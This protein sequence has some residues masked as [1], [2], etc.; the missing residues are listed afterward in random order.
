MD[1][2]DIRYPVGQPFQIGVKSLAGHLAPEFLRRSHAGPLDAA[3]HVVLDRFEIVQLPVEMTGQQQNG[4]FKFALAIVQRA[5]AKIQDDDGGADDDGRD[6]QHAANDK[7]IERVA[8][9][10]RRSAAVMRAASGTLLPHRTLPRRCMDTGVEWRNPLELGLP[11][12]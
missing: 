8:P 5:F 11:A 4:I 7:P 3:D 6:Q 9:I 1:G 10:E 2:G 12:R